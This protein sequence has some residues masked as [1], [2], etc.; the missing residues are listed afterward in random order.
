V[1]ALI[2]LGGAALVAS[3]IVS[4]TP[5]HSIG[6][7]SDGTNVMMANTHPIDVVLFVCRV[8]GVLALLIGVLALIGYSRREMDLPAEAVPPES[9]TTDG[10]LPPTPPVNLTG[11]N[12]L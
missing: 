10:D 7:A 2:L 8:G 11:W 6:R 5:E 1:L 9:H 3:F 4:G 12:R